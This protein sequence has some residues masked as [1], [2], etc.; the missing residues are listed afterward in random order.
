MLAKHDEAFVRRE[1]SES[2][3][4][5][6]QAIGRPAHHLAYPVGDPTSA[7]PRE[8]A[9][10]RELGFVSAVTTR[11]GMIFPE[12]AVHPTALPRLSVNGNYQSLDML[13]ILLSGAPFALWNRG[14][15]VNAA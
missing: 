1:L 11:P 10:A 4:R 13:D 7:G 12:H 14:R 2:R 9:I 3:A 6:E 8:F 15:R 5:I